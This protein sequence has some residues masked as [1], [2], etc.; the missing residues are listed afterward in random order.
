MGAAVAFLMRFDT[1]VSRRVGVACAVVERD[2]EPIHVAIDC[3]YSQDSARALHSVG[4]QLSMIVGTNRRARRPARLHATSF[5]GDVAASVRQKHAID[6]WQDMDTHADAFTEVPELLDAAGG[7]L[8]N[9]V[10][11]SPDGEEVLTGEVES[12]VVYVFAGL[13]DVNPPT[14]NLSRARAESLGVRTARLPVREFYP[15]A[16]AT[17]MAISRH[18]QSGLGADPDAASIVSAV[19]CVLTKQTTASWEEVMEIAV[20]NRIK[21]ARKTR[22]KRRKGVA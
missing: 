17:V 1:A 6:A 9:F 19:E 3:G 22:Y 18:T 10:Y 11:M 21:E 4:K 7:D 15:G 2:Y 14:P 8:N 5:A 16:S 13:I 20:P 12:G